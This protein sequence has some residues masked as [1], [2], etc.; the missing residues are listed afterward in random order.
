[1]RIVR[2]V[3][4]LCVLAGSVA[5]QE[6]RG[7]LSGIVTD[8]SGAVVPGATMQLTNV[9]TGVVLSTTSN[10]A[11]LYRFLFLKRGKYKVVASA[12]GFKTFER[13]SIPLSGSEAGRLPVVLGLG[14][15]VGR[16][17]VAAG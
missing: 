7:S 4:G 14:E 16:I 5:A 1:M 12:T 10:E 11:G 6:T 8:S 17:A 15:H 3:F 13:S 9:D 2:L